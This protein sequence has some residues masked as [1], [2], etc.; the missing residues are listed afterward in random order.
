METVLDI[1]RNDSQVLRGSE[2][3]DGLPLPNWIIYIDTQMQV[4]SNIRRL[5]IY[6]MQVVMH[7]IVLQVV[8]RRASTICQNHFPMQLQ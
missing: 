5:H 7:P 3:L 6:Q 4:K 2:G 1:Y 8:V